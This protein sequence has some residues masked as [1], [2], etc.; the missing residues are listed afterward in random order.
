MAPEEQT[1]AFLLC[2]SETL[3]FNPSWW[4]VINEGPSVSNPRSVVVGAMK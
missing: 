2:A 3:W 4:N 1:S